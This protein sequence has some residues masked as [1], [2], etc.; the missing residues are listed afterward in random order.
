MDQPKVTV[1]RTITYPLFWR[2][3]VQISTNIPKTKTEFFDVNLSVRKNFKQYFVSGVFLTH[4][5]Q[6][7]TRN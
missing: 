1:H 3:G 7:I 5:P 2:Q 4:H 6:L